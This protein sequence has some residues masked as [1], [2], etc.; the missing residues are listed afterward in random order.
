[1][2]PAG[3]IGSVDYDEKK[4][5]VNRTQDRIK[6]APEF[7]NSLTA[8]ES[9]RGRLMETHISMDARGGA[10]ADEALRVSSRRAC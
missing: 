1:L 5:F 10:K 6:S 9:Y 4:I 2:L 8:D 7:D 3:V